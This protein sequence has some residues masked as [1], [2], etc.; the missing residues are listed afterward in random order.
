MTLQVS[1]KVLQI[2]WGE[3][4][5]QHKGKGDASTPLRPVGPNLRSPSEWLIE[6]DY[7]YRPN[8]VGSVGWDSFT[9]FHHQQQQPTIPSPKR[10]KENAKNLQVISQNYN[11]LEKTGNKLHQQVETRDEHHHQQQQLLL[12][13]TDSPKLRKITDTHP[14][15]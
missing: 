11:S 4:E 6:G 9:F 2:S 5:A 10:N 8:N 12:T 15:V 13:Q 7:K 14:R 3:R 1:Y